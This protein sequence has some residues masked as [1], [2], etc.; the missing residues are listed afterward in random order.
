MIKFEKSKLPII[1]IAFWVFLLG[2]IISIFNIFNLFKY[3]LIIDSLFNP[4]S[5]VKTSVLMNDKKPYKPFVCLD[6]Y[7][8]SLDNN[9]FNKCVIHT[10]GFLLL[11]A[12]SKALTKLS[13]T[14]LV[15][16][17]IFIYITLL[18]STHSIRV[19]KKNVF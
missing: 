3:D 14:T 19:L 8:Q 9:I 5:S 17:S 4:L 15:I 16:V 6:S 18:F 11:L 2:S 1:S 7:C 10:S 13:R 12:N